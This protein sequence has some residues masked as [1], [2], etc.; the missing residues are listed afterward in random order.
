MRGLTIMIYA[1]LVAAGCVHP[2]AASTADIDPTGWRGDNTVRLEVDNTDTVSQ[3]NI[4]FLFRFD[5]AFDLRNIPLTVKV[6]TPD[7]L[8][9]EEDF[10]AVMKNPVRRNNDFYEASVPYRHSVTLSRTGRYQ[11]EVA[12]ANG[13][14]FGIW[15]L[16]LIIE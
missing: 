7:S 4:T 3:R 13:E 10:T 2:Q 6:T 16:G 15:G 12:N 8:W 11:F 9:Y 1:C 14:I 5:E